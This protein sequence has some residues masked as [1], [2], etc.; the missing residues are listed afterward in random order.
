MVS[1]L[2]DFYFVG[3]RRSYCSGFLVNKIQVCCCF[4]EEHFNCFSFHSFSAY[5]KNI[6]QAAYTHS[7]LVVKKFPLQIIPGKVSG[8]GVQSATASSPLLLGPS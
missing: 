8:T 1:L 5:S 3:L 7:F 6:I 4:S 2:M